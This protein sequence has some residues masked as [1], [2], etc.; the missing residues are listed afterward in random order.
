MVR[1]CAWLTPYL[2]GLGHPDNGIRVCT[3]LVD[4]GHKQ[5]VDERRLAQTR[6]TCLREEGECEVVSEC[7]GVWRYT[8]HVYIYTV[9]C[10]SVVQWKG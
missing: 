9:L 5:R 3:V 10:K 2:G 4:V 8:Q 7:R 6:L 1:G